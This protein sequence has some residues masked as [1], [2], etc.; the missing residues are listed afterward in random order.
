LLPVLVNID[1]VADMSEA[2]ASLGRGDADR[3]LAE[4]V[5]E[6]VDGKGTGGG[7]DGQ[8]PDAQ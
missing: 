4:A 8:E 7:P 6:V 1:Q 3:W 2:A 5:I